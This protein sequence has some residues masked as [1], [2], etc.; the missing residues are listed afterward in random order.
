MNPRSPPTRPHIGI[1]SPHFSTNADWGE[2]DAWDS[3]SDSEEPR[4]STLTSSW[5]RPVLPQSS[6]LPKKI[7]RPASN[8]SSS[9]LAFSYTHVSP[10]NPSSYPPKSDAVAPA[11]GPKNGWTIVRKASSREDGE[12][13]I[14]EG[15]V[16]DS[17]RDV[18]VDVEGDMVVGELEPEMN[19]ADGT[20]K[21]KYKSSPGSVRQDVESIVIGTH[22]FPFSLKSRVSHQA[23][24]LSAQIH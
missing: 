7:P 23:V 22:S 19:V 9:T 15:K 12:P 2:D 13:A 17:R 16:V 24:P 6:T 10:P 3:T 11:E 5:A 8:S 20:S 4:L 1:Y 18:D 21:M 14:P